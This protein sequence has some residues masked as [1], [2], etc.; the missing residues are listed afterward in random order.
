MN[1]YRDRKFASNYGKELSVIVDRKKAI[2]STWYERFP[3]SCSPEPGKHGTFKDCEAILPEIAK[4][5]F[6]VFYLPP[7]HPIGRTNRKGKNNS[8]VSGQND[9]GSPWAIGS[10]EGGHKSIHPHL[11]TLE[12]FERLINKTRDYD[13]EIALDLAFQCSPDH[14]YVAE[15]P[16]WFKWRPDGSVQYAENPPKKYEDALPFNFETEQ[17]RQL[18]EELK[19]VVVFWVERGVRIFRVDNPHTK[20]FSFWEWLIN[21]V[22]SKYP[23][24]L[25]LSEA[26]T[27]PK[28]M[29]YLAKLGF[30]QS[31]TYFTWRN[32]KREFIEYI[33]ELVQTN[34]REYFRPNFWPNTPDIL[35]EHLQYGGRPAFMIRLILA[36]TLSSSYGIFGPDFELCVSE[37]LPGKEE[38]LNSEKYEVKHCDWDRP[39]NLKDFIARVNRVRKENPALQTTGNV[40]FYEADNGYLVVYGKTTEDFSN[41]LLVVVNLDPY[42][43][44]SGWIR[45]PINKFGIDADQPYLV[46]DLLSDGKYIW[47]GENNYVEFKPHNLPAHIFKVRKK[48]K[49]ETDFDYFL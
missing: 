34:V 13:I 30:T 17:W 43:S 1:E 4:M 46:H 33:T 6:D 3:R 44:Q 18:W 45:I 27:R 29:Y 15:H 5:G 41:I 20:P 31:Y 25:F 22:K 21:E 32:T 37:A 36:A 2:F 35:P 47:H 26:F 7:I 28:V 16:E 48:L 40:Q 38:Y 11:G 12:D 19:S 10:Q 8:P 24:V 39:G 23:D 42:H 9:V 49:R 14:P